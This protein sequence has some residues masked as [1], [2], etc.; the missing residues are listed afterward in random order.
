MEKMIFDANNAILG[1]LSS[2]AAKKA[3]E[4]NEI[5]VINC[6]D[7]IIKG[8]EKDILERFRGLH[9]KG[10]GGSLKGPKI[11]KIPYRVV[12]R[13]IRGMLPDHRR[14]IGKI[15]FKKVTCY[16]DCPDEFKDKAQIRY[17]QPNHD[18]YITIK[19]LLSKM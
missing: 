19:Q 2:S 6:K 5:V 17:E 9:N 14:G 8:N 10:R 1:R 11:I 13:S 3:L 7:A 4:G 18:K 15:A 16:D 12:K